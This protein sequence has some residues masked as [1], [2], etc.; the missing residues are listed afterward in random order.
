[1]HG[2]LLARDLKAHTVIGLVVTAENYG[3]GESRV[4]CSMSYPAG[5]S[6]A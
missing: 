1:M 5:R 2:G 4:V 3:R 6:A